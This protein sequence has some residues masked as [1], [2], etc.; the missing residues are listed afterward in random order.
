[1]VV[2][3]QSQVEVLKNIQNI[4][5]TKCHM[6]KMH[7]IATVKGFHCPIDPKQSAGFDNP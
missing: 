5:M 1:M 6:I 3:E 7:V 4:F 2:K